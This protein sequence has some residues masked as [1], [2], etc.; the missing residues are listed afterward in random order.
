MEKLE[1]K[2]D[3]VTVLTDK[4]RLN[5]LAKRGPSKILHKILLNVQR[6]QHRN[7]G[8]NWEKTVELLAKWLVLHEELSHA[9]MACKAFDGLSLEKTRLYKRNEGLLGAYVAAARKDPR[10]HIGELYGELNLVQTGQNMTPLSVV[11]M[12][13][14]MTFAETRNKKCKYFEKSNPPNEKLCW[15]C[16]NSP[17]PF[18]LT[19]LDPCTGTGRFLW[20]S[21]IVNK[22]LPLV[23][24]G[25]EINLSLY[26]ACLVNMAVYA[27]H[28]YSIICGDALLLDKSGP[29]SPLWDLGN[30][31]NP[32]D[33][34][35]YHW[36]PPPP[37][38]IRKDAFS[39]K[40]W[41]A[42]NQK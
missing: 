29:T 22:N 6:H 18:P 39:L 28:P 12:M 26:R 25:I 30:R 7:S 32:P 42:Q 1:T 34:S 41:I 33:I 37:P 35:K 10:D 11:D 15:T 9:N 16:A 17:N 38:P 40:A 19:Q 24:M 2:E 3:C 21:S 14:Q 23:L 8:R 4:I 5:R 13:I 20:E 27:N 31:W 36:K